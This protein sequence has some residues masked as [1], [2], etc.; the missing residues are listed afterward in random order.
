IIVIITGTLLSTS[1]GFFVTVLG[2][3]K[4]HVQA[5][6]GDNLFTPTLVLHRTKNQQATAIYWCY[7][8]PLEHYIVA[9]AG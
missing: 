3:K 9:V 4:L 5:F 6:F 1:V 8:L 7:N 2:C